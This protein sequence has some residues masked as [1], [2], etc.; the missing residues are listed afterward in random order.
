VPKMPASK[1][2]LPVESSALVQSLRKSS[3]YQ[4]L[5]DDEGA[6]IFERR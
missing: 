6:I 3:S 2:R 1:D 5:L 4:V